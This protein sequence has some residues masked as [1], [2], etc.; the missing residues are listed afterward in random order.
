MRPLITLTIEEADIKSGLSCDRFQCP[1][2]LAAK[3]VFPY[4]IRI[5]VDGS[6]IRVHRPDKTVV[7]HLTGEASRFIYCFDQ[8]A[9]VIPCNLQIQEDYS[10]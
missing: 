10:Y 4:A 3:R 1:V 2:A 8:G 7:Y 6:Q 9:T 5:D